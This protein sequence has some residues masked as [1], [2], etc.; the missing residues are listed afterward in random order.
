M[1]AVAPDRSS[2][3]PH[4]TVGVVVARVVGRVV[5]RLV[6]GAADDEVEGPVVAAPAA[7]GTVE[8]TEPATTPDVAVDVGFCVAPGPQATATNP[9]PTMALRSLRFIL[10]TFRP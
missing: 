2:M 10:F 3:R 7:G 6:E 1:G 8:A 4:W 5:G 9:A